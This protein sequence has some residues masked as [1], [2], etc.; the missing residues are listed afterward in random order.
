[1]VG[2]THEVLCA[3]ARAPNAI[4][5][6]RGRRDRSTN[7]LVRASTASRGFDCDGAPRAPPLSP[8]VPAAPPR[9]PASRPVSER[10]FVTSSSSSSSRQP[11]QGDAAAPERVSALRVAVWVAIAIVLATGVILYFRHQDEVVPVLGAASGEASPR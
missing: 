5:A 11:A 10:P 1:M 8:R 6:R 9:P 4:V 7:C 3:A 2:A